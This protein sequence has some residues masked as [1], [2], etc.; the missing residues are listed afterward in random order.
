MLDKAR[1]LDA[2]GDRK[3]FDTVLGIAIIV[4]LAVT[5]LR[6]RQRNEILRVLAAKCRLRVLSLYLLMPIH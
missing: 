3:I 5:L 1:S 4:K 6:F 2:D